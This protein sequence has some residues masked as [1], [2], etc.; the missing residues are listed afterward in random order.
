MQQIDQYIKALIFCSPQ[1]IKPEEIRQ[2]LA[3]AFEQEMGIELVEESIG[4]I[5]DTFRQDH[6]VFE[7]VRAGGGYQFM[8][9]PAYHNLV[10]TL[11]KQQSKKRL[12]KTA[13]ETLSI[14]AYK[15][16]VSKTEI[17]QVRGVNADYAIKKLLDRNLVEIRGKSD[18]P[19]RPMLYGTTDRFLEHFGINDLKE[20]PALKD[21]DQE[22]ESFIEMMDKPHDQ[23]KTQD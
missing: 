11:L 12:S 14:I 4:R 3:E 15:Q 20:L 6:E 18:S 9:K 2:C 17:E 13:L 5:D 22:D 10:A 7:L 8:T 23:T 16:P 1:P 19:G 21:F